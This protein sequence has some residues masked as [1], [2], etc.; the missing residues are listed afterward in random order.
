MSQSQK[1]KCRD[2]SAEFCQEVVRGTVGLDLMSAP[3]KPGPGGAGG[4][5]PLENSLQTISAAP[6]AMKT[7]LNEGAGRNP[8]N[9]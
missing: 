3:A 1:W 2:S 7:I 6:Q 8:F 5:L 4:C 9:S